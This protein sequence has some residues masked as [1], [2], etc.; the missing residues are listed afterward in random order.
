MNRPR[1]SAGED[2]H[3]RDERP[4]ALPART[5]AASARTGRR[6]AR[7]STSRARAASAWPAERRSGEPAP[8]TA[9]STPKTAGLVVAALGDRRAERLVRRDRRQQDEAG[10]EDDQGR[11]R[12][13]RAARGSRRRARPASARVAA[14]SPRSRGRRRT[15]IAA[16]TKKVAASTANAS[17]APKATNSRLPIA[18]P[19][20]WDR[21]WR[22]PGDRLRL[23][24]QLVRDGLR[25]QAGLGRPEERLGGAEA[26]LDDR[27]RRDRRLAQRGS[28]PPARVC[29]A[30]RTRSV[31]IMTRWRGSRS[32]HTPPISSSPTNG[33]PCAASTMPTSVGVPISLTYSASTTSTRLSPVTETD[34]DSHSRRNSRND[35]T[36]RI[37][38]PL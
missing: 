8:R 15:R 32:A 23:G 30:P 12:A 18:G 1:P 27:D 24:D 28:G 25:D 2:G 20:N 3:R 22:E 7:R 9:A 37:A 33:M 19:M 14:A 17:A 11:P 34:C 5:A 13:A 36:R 16:D 21:L 10:A 26:R 6:T 38:S 35:R 31:P 4:A 29:S